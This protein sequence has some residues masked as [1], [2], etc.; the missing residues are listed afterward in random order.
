M[1]DVQKNN[2]FSNKE[3]KTLLESATTK[4]FKS[5]SNI[6]IT[7]EKYINTKIKLLEM[8]KTINKKISRV[9]NKL[10][11]A[12]KN[13]WIKALRSGD[14]KQGRFNLYL[15]GPNKT[16]G[17]YCCLG[18]LGAIYGISSRSLNS[19]GDYSKEYNPNSHKAA[20]KCKLPKMMLESVDDN[21]FL[22]K[23]VD[24]NDNK[25]NSFIQIAKYIEK[26]L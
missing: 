10:P 12:I 4:E 11:K 19:E 14:Y 16:K 1:K 13:K 17:T 7:I 5:P 24:M 23:L 20:I 8:N 6:N 18:V 22:K 3:L 2:K 9:N 26:N 15:P 21:K 25:N